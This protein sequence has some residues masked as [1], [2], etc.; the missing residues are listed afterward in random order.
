MTR[1]RG[2]S[3]AEVSVNRLHVE[4]NVTSCHSKFAV[5]GVINCRTIVRVHLG[6]C[7]E[8]VNIYRHLH[9]KYRYLR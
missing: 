6:T 3:G 5:Y 9:F 4:I 1:G 7:I 8:S 2:G